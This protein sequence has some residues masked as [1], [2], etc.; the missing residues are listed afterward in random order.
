MPTH[1]FELRNPVVLIHG[2][3]AKSSYGP[4]DYFFGLPKL[5]RA[6][7]NSV[8]IADLTAWQTIEHRAT[9]LKTQI[10][11]AF[12]EGKVNLIGHSLG[13]LD[14]RYLA[15]RLGFSERIASITTIGTPNRGSSMADLATGLL[16]DPALTMAD[17]FLFFLNSSSGALKQITRQYCQEEFNSQVAPDAPGVAYFSVTTAIPRPIFKYA[18]PIFWIPHRIMNRI[19]GDNDGF[20]SVESAKWGDH[21]G[22]FRGDHYAQ[23][24]QFLGRSR[25]LDYIRFYNEIFGHL[26]KN[27][28]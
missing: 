16:P 25:G 22:T 24:G 3:G 9:Q 2:L 4:V 27:G 8:L 26:K 11:R 13:G 14:A 28:M 5:L 15:S 10:E 6:A 21:I 23:I 1:P 18:L 17:R 12:P 19:E 20:V 7:R